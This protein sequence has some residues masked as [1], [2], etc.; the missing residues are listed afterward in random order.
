MARSKTSAK[1]IYTFIVASIV[2][3]LGLAYV[4]RPPPRAARPAATAPQR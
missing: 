4:F 3:I 1:A 2:V